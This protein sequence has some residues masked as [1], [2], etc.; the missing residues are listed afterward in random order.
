MFGTLNVPS[1]LGYSFFRFHSKRQINKP[2]PVQLH[3][4]EAIFQQ[5]K[6]EQKNS[7][8]AFEEEECIRN[9]NSY[10]DSGNSLK[11]MADDRKCLKK[12]HSTANL[13]N[14]ENSRHLAPGVGVRVLSG[15]F[16][17]FTGRLKELDHKSGK[18][19]L[20]DTQMLS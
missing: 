8:Q 11:S 15:P 6:E 2:K 14:G 20:N 9:L 5:A 13:L 4:M 12:D 19:L 18:V 17:E 7:D 3:E 16:T 10:L 1:S